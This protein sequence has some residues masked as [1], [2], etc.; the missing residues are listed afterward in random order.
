L[1]GWFPAKGYTLGGR[2]TSADRIDPVRIAMYIPQSRYKA[3]HLI[4]VSDD[5]KDSVPVVTA[6][7]YRPNDGH[8]LNFA[9][10]VPTTQGDA[11]NAKAVPIKLASGQEAKLY[12]V[13][14]PLDPDAFSW[15][16]D[17]SRI[18]ME[19]TKQIQFYR[20]YPDPAEYS[21]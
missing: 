11:A 14:I 6:Q 17:L 19:I 5:R 8:P 4:A 7:F 3:L 13:T 1:M 18:G 2:W 20:G 21:W 12:H 15:F 16:T 10:T 9:G